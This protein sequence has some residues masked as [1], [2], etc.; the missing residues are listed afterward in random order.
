MFQFLQCDF[1]FILFFSFHFSYLA[2]LEG[3]QREKAHNSAL[4][5]CFDG[6]RGKKRPSFT[7]EQSSNHVFSALSET[8]A[9]VCGNVLR[10]FTDNN[11]FFQPLSCL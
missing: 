1:Y 4:L 8:V 10:I 5:E 9:S 2:H 3:C 11:T 7:I 6:P